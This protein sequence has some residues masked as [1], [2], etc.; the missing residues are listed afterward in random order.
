[1]RKTNINPTSATV[2][3]GCEV[4][5]P[6]L[7]QS[8]CFNLGMQLPSLLSCLSCPWVKILVVLYVIERFSWPFVFL[9]CVTVEQWTAFLLCCEDERQYAQMWVIVVA[10]VFTQT[11]TRKPSLI[12][13][14]KSAVWRPETLQ[15]ITLVFQLMSW[16]HE[17]SVSQ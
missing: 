13:K 6:S 12:T 3:P 2:Y 1:M 15:K 10:Q 9:F 16:M 11:P 7:Y 4:T 17:I 8:S 14:Y 5:V